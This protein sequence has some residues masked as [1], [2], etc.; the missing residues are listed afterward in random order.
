LDK[1]G[2]GHAPLLRAEKLLARAAEVG[3]EWTDPREVLKKLREEIDELETAI[4]QGL[5]TSALQDELGDVLFCTV[6]LARVFTIDS[7]QALTGGID[8]FRRRFGFIESSLMNR[9]ESLSSASLEEMVALWAEAKQ[10]G[11]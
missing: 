3:Y 4:E 11:L 9:G 5:P 6:N 1:V 2:T 7:E 10:Q 8:K